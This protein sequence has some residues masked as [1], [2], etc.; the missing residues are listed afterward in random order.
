MN[1]KYA[2]KHALQFNNFSN[3]WC[4]KKIIANFTCTLVKCENTIHAPKI[5]RKITDPNKTCTTYSS[6]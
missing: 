6:F 5:K 2:I 1:K 3:D 4:F